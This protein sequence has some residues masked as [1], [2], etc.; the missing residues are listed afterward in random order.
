MLSR[1]YAEHWLDE[2]ARPQ[3]GTAWGPGFAISWQ[4]GPLGKIESKD[5]R[6]PNGAFVETVI[7]AV[8]NRISHY[9]QY[10]PCQENAEALDYL[11]HALEALN[12][13]T[14]RRI[15]EGVEGTHEGS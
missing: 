1:F 12:R 10:F 14:H 13:R 6:E 2:N 15:N 7:A 5:R 3:G 9:Q 11:N 4:H 8:V